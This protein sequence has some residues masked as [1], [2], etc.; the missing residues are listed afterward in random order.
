MCPPCRHTLARATAFAVALSALTFSVV[1][2]RPAA[3][4]D[5]PGIIY[6]YEKIHTGNTTQWVL[7]PKAMTGVLS[8]DLETNVRAAFRALKAA[9]PPTY[10]RTDLVVDPA[11]LKV[12]KATV[13]IDPDKTKYAL[14]IQ[15]EALHTLESLG[16]H[17]VIFKGEE[18]V[19]MTTQSLPFAAFTLTLPIWRAL[20][21]AEAPGAWVRMPDASLIAAETF[22]QRLNAAD[23]STVKALYTELE[24]SD[25]ISKLGIL[26]R[27]PT[28]KLPGW[29]D[30]A[31]GRLRDPDPNVQLAAIQALSGISQRNVLDQIAR[32]LEREA[33]PAVKSAA[34]AVLSASDNPNYNVFGLYHALRGDDVEQAQAAVQTMVDRKLTD[35][36]PEI[37]KALSHN[38]LPIA[39]RAATGLRQLNAEKELLKALRDNAL[40]PDLRLHIATELTQVRDRKDAFVG[41]AFLAAN[42]E[43]QAALDAI[44]QLRNFKD[45]DPM[46]ALVAALAN[47]DADARHAAAIAILSTKNSAALPA[48]AK[49]AADFPL[50]AQHFEAQ[51]VALL[52]D[53]E[54][55]SDI[56]SML[57]REKEPLIRR[58]LFQALA[59]KAAGAN[60]FDS[61]RERLLAG[62]NE[63]DPL[64]RGGALLGLAHAAVNDDLPHITAQAKH[65]SPSVRIDVAVALRRFPAGQASDVLRALCD[66]ATPAVAVAALGTFGARAEKAYLREIT[67][68]PKSDH[69]EVRSA[70]IRATTAMADD[71]N[72]GDV[73]AFVS[74]ALFDADLSVKLTAI[75]ALG[76]LRD[77]QAIG[78]LALMVQDPDKTIQYATFLALGKSQNPDAA[79]MLATSLNNPDPE[80]RVRVLQAIALH[81]A[82]SL[83]QP[84][85]DL[86]ATEGE[87]AVRTA[88]DAALRTIGN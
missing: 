52:V 60:R 39:K 21:P 23:P 58:V 20:P 26:E 64:V 55:L 12:G 72:R 82:L 48:M 68:M 19:T 67:R 42:A 1:G 28:L 45:P 13:S 3:A 70:M 4:Q 6:S 34:A 73:I 50:Q 32:L 49:A 83:R 78:A 33:T 22:T 77:S 24:Q 44:E 37:I 85:Q 25:P 62:I 10:G 86:L 38:R 47:P 61:A 27:L 54:K 9:K 56:E 15:A 35:A 11:Q 40:N 7:I 75:E 69:H 36:T 41:A 51:M 57:K 53:A 29:E 2:P 5:G 65:E 88:A 71:A 81:G 76:E 31:M 84:I 18:Q 74:N 87:A 30:A 8:N 14:I 59:I 16:I 80:T 66:D 43:G 46:D 17:T 63:Q 79:Q